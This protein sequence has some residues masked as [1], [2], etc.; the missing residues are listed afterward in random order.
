MNK[1]PEWKPSLSYYGQI[2]PFQF[3]TAA[4]L[5]QAVECFHD[6]SSPLYR[7][8]RGMAPGFVILLPSEAKPFLEERGIAFEIAPRSIPK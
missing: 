4:D 5:R 8:P 6:S 7:V 3:A 2:L 1:V